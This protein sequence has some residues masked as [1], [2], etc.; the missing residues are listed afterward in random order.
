MN[1]HFDEVG[2]KFRRDCEI[3]ISHTKLIICELVQFS[4][5]NQTR[6]QQQEFIQFE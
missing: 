4:P 6:N 5:I 2:D 1:E 3:S